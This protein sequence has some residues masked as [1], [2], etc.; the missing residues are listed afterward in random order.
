MLSTIPQSPVADC[1]IPNIMV[2]FPARDKIIG[3]TTVIAKVMT[4]LILKKNKE[5]TKKARSS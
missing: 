3:D 4:R 5:E 1:T 2:S